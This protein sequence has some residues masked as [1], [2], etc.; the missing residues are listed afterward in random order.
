MGEKEGFKQQ[1]IQEL[2]LKPVESLEEIVHSKSFF[3]DT[4]YSSETEMPVYP[5]TKKANLC[6]N[7]LCLYGTHWR[8]KLQEDWTLKKEEGDL[9]RVLDNAATGNKEHRFAE[10]NFTKKYLDAHKSLFIFVPE[11]F[12][13]D[14]FQKMLKPM[15][16]YD[17]R[18]YEEQKMNAKKKVYLH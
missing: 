4:N 17:L 10:Y 18:D 16:L 3:F 12:G 14:Y 8:Y 11:T 13:W 2:D 9:A 1:I 7:L 15:F 6:H 5:V